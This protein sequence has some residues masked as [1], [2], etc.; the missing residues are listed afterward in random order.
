MAGSRERLG[1]ALN[2]VEPVMLGLFLAENEAVNCLSDAELRAPR[3]HP[4]VGPPRDRRDGRLRNRR[5]QHE[6][7]VVVGVLADQVD[8]AECFGAGRRRDAEQSAELLGVDHGAATM[9]QATGTST[10]RSWAAASSGSVS[11]VN[12]PAPDSLPARYFKRFGM[13]YAG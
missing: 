10:A 4:I 5:R 7:V 9:H 12:T 8:A 13:R 3:A 1:H 2:V 11:A 6:S